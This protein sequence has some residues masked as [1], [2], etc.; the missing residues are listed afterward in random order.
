M[1]LK[2]ISL[3]FALIAILAV[4][5]LGGYFLSKN[6]FLDRFSLPQ[7]KHTAFLME[8]YDKIKEN[9]WDKL[10]NEKLLEYCLLYTSPSP[11]DS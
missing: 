2:K 4:G 1:N 10:S 3:A 5:L 9:Y 7:D 11:R 6:G 8:V